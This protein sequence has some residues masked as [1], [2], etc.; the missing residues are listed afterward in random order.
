M[1]IVLNLKCAGGVKKKKLQWY[2][3]GGGG[4]VT[5]PNFR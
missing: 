2:A 4:E 5:S 3:G 1:L